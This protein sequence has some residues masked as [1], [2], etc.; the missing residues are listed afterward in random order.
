MSLAK[1]TPMPGK[2]MNLYILLLLLFVGT[3]FAESIQ[4]KP[5]TI[6]WR[7]NAD[8]LVNLSFL[9][10]APAGKDGFILVSNGHLTKPNGERFRIWGVNFTAASCFPSKED[11]PVVAEHLARFGIN[12]VRFHFLDSNWSGSL[13]IDGREDTR[14]LNP[15]QL[16]RFDYFVTELKKQGIYTNIN[17]N[18]GRN[19]RKGDGV[20]DY[21]YLGLAKV[22][23]YFDEHIQLLHKEYAKQLLTHYNPYTKSEYRHEPAIAVVELVNENSIVE[24]WFSDRLLGKNTNKRPGTWADITEGYANQLTKKYN[25]WLKERLSPTE[26]K[27]L[28]NMAGVKEDELI[29][30]LTKNQFAASPKKRFHMEATFYMELEHNYFH[31]MYRYLK[32][33]LEIRAL[34]VG[35]SDHNHWKSGYPLLTSTSRL[36]VVDGHVYWQHP[37]YLTDPKTGRRTFSIPNTPMVNDPLNSTVVRLSRS[38]VAGKPFTVS[39]TNHP[40]P[41][42]YA[43]EGAGILAAYSAFHDWDGVFFHEFDTRA[44]DNGEARI[45]GHFRIC[46]DPVKMTNLAA[47]AVMFLGDHVQQA[48]ETIPRSYSLRQVRQSIRRPSSE[49]PYFTPGFLPSIPLRHTTRIVGF[50]NEAGEYPKVSSDSPIVSDTSEL[51]WHYSEQKKG[52]VTVETEKSQALIGFVKDH[53]KVL[54]NLSATVENEFCSVILTALDGRTIPRS[55]KLLLVAT[56]RSANAGM[57]WN[58]NR[59]SLSNW[60]IAPTVIEPVR[61]KVILRNLEPLQQIE[62]IPLDGAGKAQEYTVSVHNTKKDF[63]FSIGEQATTW[64]L[65]RIQR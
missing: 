65:V 32:D 40:F 45:S 19:Y 36:D 26:L 20:K 34:I 29:P 60:G 21:D 16:D 28:R 1:E 35:T 39:E 61:G 62:I 50:D 15:Q 51:T 52:L 48:I 33:E 63:I 30:R 31:K 64:Y 17:L 6:D 38:A 58:E 23:N 41:N 49:R 2:H 3:A 22:V 4:M 53:N 43:C 12:C 9:L 55:K 25:E 11:A 47:C 7:E 37:R 59:T 13:F 24:A 8:S 42:E 54:K 27:A 18:V 46:R 5:F 57:I 56:A 44:Y 14:A 10:D